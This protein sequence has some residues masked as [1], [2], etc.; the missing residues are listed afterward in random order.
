MITLGATVG[1]NAAE[2]PNVILILGDDYSCGEHGFY[3]ND[4]I[5]TPNLDTLAKESV[6]FDNFYVGPTSSPT[7]AQLLSGRHEFRCGITHTRYP[8]AYMR[9]DEKLLP[10]YLLEEG[11]STAHF[12]KWHLGNDV[13][14]DEYSA[15]ARGFEHSIVSDYREHF[16]PVMLYN[17]EHK[18]YKGFRE[19]ILFD[20]APAWMSEQI[21]SDKPFFCYIATNSAHMP[22]GCPEEYIDRYRGRLQGAGDTYYGLVNNIDD[23]VGEIIQ[24]LKDR[25]EYENTLLIYLSDNGHT[26]SGYNAN[27]RGGK[28]SEYRGG[29][30]VPYLMHCPVMFEG[31]RK[32]GEMAGGVDMLPTLADLLDFNIEKE[33]D[34]VSLKPLLDGKKRELKDR[35]MV[36]HTGRWADGEAT[37]SKYR[38]Y[39]VQNRRYRLVNNEEL[40]DIESDPSETKNIIDEHPKLVA[41]MRSFYDK[42]WAESLPEMINDKLSLNQGGSRLSIEDVEFREL[43]R[44]Q[45]YKLPLV[46]DMVHHNPG[47]PTYESSYN[48]PA[49]MSSMGYNGKIY[50]LFE[51]PMLAIN[52]ESVDKNILPEGC[53]DREWVD[54][55]AMQ[56]KTMQANC[57]QAGLLTLAQSDLV[58][59]PKR[60]VELYN[61]EESMGDPRNEEIERLIRAQINEMFDQFPLLDG[62][63]TRIGE[64]YMHDAPYHMGN[65]DDKNSP[66][67]TIIPLLKILRD[68]ICVK[69]GKLLIFRSWES[70]DRNLIDYMKVSDGVEP[71]ENLILSIKHCEGDFHRSNPFS[72][73]IGEGQHKQIIE[74][75]CAREYE[76]KGA[77]P[78][79]IANGVIEGFEEY[80]TMPQEQLNSIGEFARKH[81]DMYAGVWTWTR[82]GGWHGPY[83]KDEMWCDLNAWVMAQWAIDPTQREEDVF[84]RYATDMLQLNGDDVAKFRR[85]CLLSADAV[86][87]GKN[88]I[89]ADISPWWSRDEGIG[90]PIFNKGADLERIVEQKA[91]AVDIWREIVGLAKSINW[92][93]N[94]TKQHVIGSC[95][96]GLHLYKIYQA[97]VNL[98]VAELQDDKAAI[99]K[100]IESYDAAWIQYNTL[101]TKYSNIATLYTQEYRQGYQK[102]HAD[103]EVDRLRHIE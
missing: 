79:Y 50:F 81:P 97:V 38:K 23:N 91:E 88:T 101:A 13:F 29:T 58:L 22:Y 90:W 69:R 9:L 57:T 42:W 63:V 94:H 34:G 24:Y 77:Y 55:K 66:E 35:F 17:G 40:Y 20:E 31:G 53:E 70:F 11:Y 44:E 75:Q 93:D 48:N 12:G 103:S 27:M 102:T 84:N 41:N 64:T 89:E 43:Q 83:I 67:K 2:Q 8:R 80:D 61:L 47:E 14:D 16:N 52:W 78:N 62:L 19:D 3:G 39:A 1:I 51:S 85:L 10:E 76:G 56:I 96:Y 21:E 99:A 37:N 60:L 6:W 49:M 74:V 68:E 73:V 59:F 72:K 46:L 4:I 87:R 86:V 32:I 36:C 45:E 82:G 98:R 25:G 26:Y 95:C 7:R 30:R 92:A 33:V 5:Q 18:S 65:I 28:N 100:W 71:H 54:N 15:R